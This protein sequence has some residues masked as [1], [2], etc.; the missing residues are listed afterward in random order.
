ML[1]SGLN[2]VWRWFAT[3]FSFSLFGVGALVFGLLLLPFSALAALSPK[4][5][6]PRVQRF[7]RRI[8]GGLLRLFIAVM[9]GLGVLTYQIAGD[10][11]R[12]V[13]GPL[14]IVANHPSLIDVVFLLA[15]YPESQ[16]VVKRGLW[17]NPFTHFMMRASGYISN[18]DP[19]LMLERSLESLARGDTLILF[20]EGTRTEPGEALQFQGAAA[21]IAVRSRCPLLPVVI[22]VTPTTLTRSD[23]WYSVPAEKVRMSLTVQPVFTPEP[24]TSAS[25]DARRAA[26]ALNADLKRMFENALQNDSVIKSGL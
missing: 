22:R 8:I 11:D 24:G 3:V 12:T 17:L 21:A 5:N 10:Y 14:L 20:P 18:H 7:F 15:M 23:A 1:L 2:R 9:R 25:A 13:R 4:G 19:V 6:S 26:R 16:C